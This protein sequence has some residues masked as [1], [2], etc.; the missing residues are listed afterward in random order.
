M[1]AGLI[2][3]LIVSL[4]VTCVLELGAVR[5]ASA[6]PGLMRPGSRALDEKKEVGN[7]DEGK[8]TDT[9]KND[10]QEKDKVEVPVD[11]LPKVVVTGVKKAMP[12]A[13]ITKASKIEKDDKITYYLDNVKVGKKAW[14]ITVDAD[15]KVIKKEECHD[16]D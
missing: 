14:D 3:I 4:S 12:G 7:K 6:D 10:D 11:K 1:S 13:R 2:R 9:D 15:G 8:K 16:D 5:K